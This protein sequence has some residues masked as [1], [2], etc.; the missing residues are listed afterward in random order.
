M[1]AISVIALALAIAGCKKTEA[2]PAPA[3][4]VAAPAPAP[5]SADAP[6]LLTVGAPA[7][8]IETQAHNGQKVSLAELKG[9]P[10][11][12]YF[13]PKD[14]TPGCTVEAQEIRD[15]F[16]DL[17]KANAV[18]LGVSTQDNTSHRAFASKYGLPFML[19]PDEDH[20]IAKAFGVPVKNG[21]AKRVTFVIDKQGKIAKVFP[22]VNPKGHSEEI[23]DA[24]RSLT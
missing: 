10:V 19:L 16:A 5:L 23:L 1:R 12:V 18:V 7:P 24:L 22:E 2:P 8:T 4:T 3:A 11:I 9:R 6:N 15:S 13:Y 17:G 14:D 21:Y 20:A